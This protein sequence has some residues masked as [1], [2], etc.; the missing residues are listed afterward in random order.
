MTVN[1]ANQGIPEQQ[2]TDP[3]NLPSA[4]ASWDGVME[5]RLVQRFTNEADRTARRPA[6]FENE[7]S[8]LASEDRV[9][10]NN[11]ASWVSL[12]Q[13]SFY[14]SARMSADQA[15]TVSST[16]L[17]NITA[18]VAALPT[19]G[20]FGFRAS[21]FFDGPTTGDIKFAFTWPA[22]VTNGRWSIIGPATTV[23]SNIGDGVFGPIQIAS[24]S[25]TGLGT[26]GTG[27]TSGS[28][29]IVEGEL[30]MGG[31]AGNLQ[32]QAAQATA[33]AGTTTVRLGSKL[34]VWRIV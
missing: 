8:A 13:R 29:A 23:A 31:T 25:A 26:S 11:S 34:W 24:G 4:Q 16:T 3:A 2:G 14:V 5:N 30:T 15:L 1:S 12:F 21:L 19:G 9:E 7:L 28:M 32:L 17:Q 18:L 10:V 20:T 27:I 22:G 33:D 6:S